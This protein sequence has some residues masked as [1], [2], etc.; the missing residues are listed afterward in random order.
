[1]LAD[2]LYFCK[3]NFVDTHTHLYCDNFDSDRADVMKS[4]IGQGVVKMILPNEDSRSIDALK[5]MLYLYGD[6]CY[7]AMGLHPSSVN[8]NYADELEII[9]QE[10]FC[11]TIKYVAIGEIG[12]D[13]YWDTKYEKQQEEVLRQQFDWAIQLNLPVIIHSRK[14][15]SKVINILNENKY[16]DI[17]GVFHCWSGTR[18]ETERVLKRG[19]FY[20]GIGGTCTYKNSKLPEILIKIGLDRILLETDSPYLSPLPFRGK[21]NDSSNIPL[22]ANKLSAIKGIALGGISEVTNM[23][24]NNLFGI[25]V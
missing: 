15:E 10:L 8:E 19:N 7:G 5:R 21:R 13:L 23:N 20:F 14:S 9:R 3:M 11:G 2:L 24:V 17:E 18:E 12:M 16:R 22:I 6:S 1:M 25:K 4:C